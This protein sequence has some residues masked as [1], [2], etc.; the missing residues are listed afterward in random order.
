MGA[1]DAT[2]GT[3]AAWTEATLTVLRRQRR[4]GVT[5]AALAV[6]FRRDAADVDRACWALMGRTPAQA[7]RALSKSP[8][9]EGAHP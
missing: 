9:P 6:A 2:A 3:P 5:L 4:A 1:A 8:T 7:V